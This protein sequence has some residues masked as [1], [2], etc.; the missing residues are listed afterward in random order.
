MSVGHGLTAMP[1]NTV[2]ISLAFITLYLLS[3]FAS[4]VY[5]G[6]FGPLSKFPGPKFRAFSRIPRIVS[7]M[8]GDE[9][10]TLPALHKTYGSVVRIAP[11]ELSFSGDAQTFKDV[12]GFKKA[13]QNSVY[14]DPF[15]YGKPFNN[16]DSVI[17]ADDANHSRQRKLIA[18]AFAD[19]SLK[20]LE[21]MLKQWA[22]MMLQKL[23][24]RVGEP[25][26]ILKFYNCTTFDISKS[27]C[28]TICPRLYRPLTLVCVPSGR[29][30]LQRRS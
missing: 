13:G 17:T 7:I 11:T 27:F 22:G 30:E 2:T 10:T 28:Y 18:H 21:P 25:V 15:F 6:F 26:D 9:A 4:A 3:T 14:K 16:V 1:V 19:K 12:H 20:D 8:R 24:E 5:N 23:T 29:S